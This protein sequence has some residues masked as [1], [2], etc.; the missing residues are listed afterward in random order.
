ML[1]PSPRESGGTKREVEDIYLIFMG[2]ENVIHLPEY[3]QS[4]YM[5][6][7]IHSLNLILKKV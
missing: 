5:E 4:S 7:S 3:K 1:L 2:E 6:V